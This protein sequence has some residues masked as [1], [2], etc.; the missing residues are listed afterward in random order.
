MYMY[1]WDSVTQTAR[2]Y[3]NDNVND[4][5]QCTTSNMHHIKIAC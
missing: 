1:V 2:A 5:E 3:D 4:N